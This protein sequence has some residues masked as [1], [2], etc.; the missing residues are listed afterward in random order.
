MKAHP[1]FRLLARQW[2]TGAARTAI[3]DPGSVSERTLWLPLAG[4]GIAGLPVAESSGGSGGGWADLAVALEALGGALAP[5]PAVAAAGVLGALG[6]LPDGSA[7]TLLPGICEGTTIA[8][9][10]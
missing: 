8:T 2:G 5:V 1:R 4:L 7:A 3:D 6:S 9:I 10:A